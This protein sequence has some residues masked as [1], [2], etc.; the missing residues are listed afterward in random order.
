M[1]FT[2]RTGVCCLS[3]SDLFLNPI[4]LVCKGFDKSN[5]DH[6]C[7]DKKSGIQTFVCHTEMLHGRIHTSAGDARGYLLCPDKTGISA[8]SKAD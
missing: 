1:S 6:V 3:I 4:Y 5:I 7:Q 2:Q 8:Q